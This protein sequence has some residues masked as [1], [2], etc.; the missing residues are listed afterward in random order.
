M[1]GYAGLTK[2]TLYIFKVQYMIKTAQKLA[3]FFKSPT[4]LI[5]KYKYLYSKA[6]C[7]CL[8]FTHYRIMGVAQ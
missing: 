5:S 7:N 2:R 1:R 8:N 4:V 6:S 3:A